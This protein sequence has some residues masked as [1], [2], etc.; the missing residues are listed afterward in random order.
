MVSQSSNTRWLQWHWK[1]KLEEV[2]WAGVQKC[3]H[4]PWDWPHNTL[5]P[6]PFFCCESDY[7]CL[8]TYG[9]MLALKVS[10][11]ERRENSII[12]IPRDLGSWVSRFSPPQKTDIFFL[13]SWP[14]VPNLYSVKT[15]FSY[16]HILCS[17][18]GFL[19]FEKFC[20]PT[21]QVITTIFL[22]GL[23]KPFV[24]ECTLKSVL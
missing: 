9:L 10:E 19:W 16:I 11:S 13:S 22:S 3:S 7:L 18:H 1:G 2:K 20:L 14:V 21:C 8:A 15:F 23:T 17:F 6:C 4:S 24:T 12:L 5:R